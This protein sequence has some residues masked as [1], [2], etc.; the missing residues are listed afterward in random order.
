MMQSEAD[1][2]RQ[3]HSQPSLLGEGLNPAFN[4]PAPALAVPSSSSQANG[5]GKPKSKRKDRDRG[6][7]DTHLDSVQ[8][9][10]TGGDTPVMERNKAMRAGYLPPSQSTSQS[11]SRSRSQG[12]DA[13]SE[14]AGK[15]EGGK[16]KK[17]HE[18]RKSSISTRGK[19]ISNLF[20]GGV[21]CECLP[22]V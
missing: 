20:E 13:S 16:A 8:E 4:F 18:R 12:P 2:L 1:G 5:N 11:Q 19:R 17:G 6:G 3:S 22:P 15:K 10:P 7:G 21:I 14:V 9:L